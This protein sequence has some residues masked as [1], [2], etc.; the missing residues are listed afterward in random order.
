MKMKKKRTSY[1]HS[2]A[3]NGKKPQ[4]QKKNRKKITFEYLE[5]EALLDFML[6][7]PFL[8]FYY[9]VT[10]LCRQ[11]DLESIFFFSFRS[12]STWCVM[13]ILSIKQLYGQLMP[14]LKSMSMLIPAAGFSFFEKSSFPC[15]SFFIIFFFSFLI[16][17]FAYK[18]LVTNSDVWLTFHSVTLCLTHKSNIYINV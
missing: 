2:S 11:L 14:K 5:L 8:L 16:W 18:F 10:S 9:F 6:F 15:S 3:N 13:W 7:L 4:K 17:S 1:T 12:E